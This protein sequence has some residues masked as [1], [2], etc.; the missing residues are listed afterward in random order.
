MVANLDLTKLKMDHLIGVKNLMVSSPLTS[1]LEHINLD[2][3]LDTDI[4][5]GNT[6]KLTG[7]IFR[8]N[9]PQRIL[10]SPY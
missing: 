6:T 2:A 5:L 7:V 10:P 3:N 4:A 8:L 1:Q 9:L